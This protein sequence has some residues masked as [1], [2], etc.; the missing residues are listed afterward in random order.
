VASKALGRSAP[1]ADKPRPGAEL[2]CGGRRSSARMEHKPIPSNTDGHGS[3]LWVRGRD[4]NGTDIFR[5]YS[6][7]NLFRG[8]LIRS[9]PSPDI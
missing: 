6:R 2:G 3:V 9:Y 4:E 5:L 1:A 7:S 8:V